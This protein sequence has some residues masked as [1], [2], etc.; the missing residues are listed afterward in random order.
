VVFWA[1]IVVAM[2]KLQ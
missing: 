1:F 2:V